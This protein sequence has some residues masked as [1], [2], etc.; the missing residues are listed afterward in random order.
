M[1]K[2][3][4]SNNERSYFMMYSYLFGPIV[5]L[6]DNR[7]ERLWFLLNQSVDCR[8]SSYLLHPYLITYCTLDN[9]AYIARQ[10]AIIPVRTDIIV[11][12]DHSCM[13]E[14][15]LATRS[16]TQVFSW[17]LST[18]R[19]DWHSSARLVYTIVCDNLFVWSLGSSMRAGDRQV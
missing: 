19:R 7:K 9:T 16:A 15:V 4:C 11:W 8:V 13:N 18:S 2:S 3:I 12:V 5:A 17:V 1:W 14:S 10:T 6:F